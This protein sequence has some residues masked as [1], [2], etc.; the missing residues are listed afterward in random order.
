[1]RP[2]THNEKFLL[3]VLFLVLFG[4]LNFFGYRALQQRESAQTLQIAQMKAD[5]AEARVSLLS[6]ATWKK[7]EAWIKQ[8]QPVA[9]D[10]GDAKAQTLQFV[11][12]AARDKGL[13]VME[14]SLDDTS[15]DSQ[16]F[17]VQIS[18]TVKGSMQALSGWLAGLQDPAGFY[19]VPEI[20]L[21]ADSDQKAMVGT[22]HICRYFKRGAS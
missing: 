13:Q 1:M 6:A 17:R 18:L 11:L 9:S 4:G 15:G 16:G 20:S 2:L 10:E 19:A 5:Q 21:K 12:K 8:H 22:L 3:G 7:R 14:Q